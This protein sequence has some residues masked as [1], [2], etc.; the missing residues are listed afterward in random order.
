MKRMSNRDCDYDMLEEFQRL[1]QI[2][3]VLDD[4]NRPQFVLWQKRKKCYKLKLLLGN[5][6]YEIGL[7]PQCVPLGFFVR[8]D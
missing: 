7:I 4:I 5:I 2:Y 6:D 8:I 1:H 3:D